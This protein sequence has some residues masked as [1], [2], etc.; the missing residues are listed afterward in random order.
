MSVWRLLDSGPAPGAWNLALDEAIFLSVRSGASPPTLRLYRW[1][2]PALSIGYAQDRDRDV[3]REAC[4]ARGIPVIRRFTGGRAV[5]HDAEVTYSVAAPAGL[6]GFGTGL[7]AAYRM[8]AAGLIAGLRLLGL[9][10]AM[11][12]PG[13]R[14]PSRPHRH[15]ACF[16]VA[17]RHEI[18]VAGRKMIGS[19]QRREGGAFLQ[20][21][22]ILLESHAELL[23][24][25][26]RGRAATRPVAGMTGLADVLPLCPAPAAVV[27]AI[28]NGCAAAWDA[29]FVPGEI[30]PAEVQAALTLEANRYRSE[31]WN[32][33]RRPGA[34]PSR[35]VVTPAHN[36]VQGT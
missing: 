6:P 23:G 12:S 16:A 31:D 13:P 17:A 3:D 35:R 28:V 11:P 5:L 32:A 8:V 27:A 4:R 10:A 21:G 14:D 22:S 36:G 34:L 9:S 7:D 30:G 26:L 25:V 19:A 1:S 15:A 29:C 24:R 2:A 33:G 20:H 18:A